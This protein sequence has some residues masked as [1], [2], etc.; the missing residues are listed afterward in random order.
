MT[1]GWE[2]DK[3][4]IC[5]ELLDWNFEV[6]EGL[7]VVNGWS[8]GS[9]WHNPL[10]YF[11]V[12]SLKSIFKF[13]CLWLVLTIPVCQGLPFPFVSHL[14]SHTPVHFLPFAHIQWTLRPQ[15]S[16]CAVTVRRTCFLGISFYHPYL[17]ISGTGCFSFLLDLIY[18]FFF[19]LV[20]K[21][22]ILRLFFLDIEVYFLPL[23]WFYMK[24]N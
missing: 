24:I 13:T 15:N 6:P 1:L 20:T 19:F 2:W 21:D 22:D 5:W 3:I 16:N 11:L 4:T 8:M 12:V 9:I 7:R 18:T 17:K 10:M 23:L 14:A